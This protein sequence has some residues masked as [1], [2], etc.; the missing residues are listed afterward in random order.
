MAISG[1]Y[2][3]KPLGADLLHRSCKLLI[4]TRFLARHITALLS[5]AAAAV[6]RRPFDAFRIKTVILLAIIRTRFF[7]ITLKIAISQRHITP[8]S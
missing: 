1:K 5:Y 7:I 2:D 8:L 6:W 4:N 3:D